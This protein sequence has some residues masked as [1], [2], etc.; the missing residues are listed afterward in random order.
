[1]H[2]SPVQLCLAVLKSVQACTWYP[3]VLIAKAGLFLQKNLSELC[4]SKYGQ[5]IILQL[6]HP[7]QQKYIPLHLQQ[8]MHPPP[9]PASGFE[10]SGEQETEQVRLCLWACLLVLS[11]VFVQW[12][13]SYLHAT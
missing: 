8:M 5:R 3:A 4:K 12:S 7:D 13:M 10:A 9:K 11:S 6:L 1:M 2:Y